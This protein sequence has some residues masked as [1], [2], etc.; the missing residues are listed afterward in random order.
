[1]ALAPAPQ[2]LVQQHIQI[3]NATVLVEIADTPALQQQGLSDRDSLEEGKGMWFVFPGETTQ[4]FWMK[5]MRFAID[6]IWVN[7][8]GVVVTIKH[9]AQPDSYPEIFYPS[10]TAQYVL[11]VPAGFTERHGIAEGTKV[12]L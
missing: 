2:Q 4:G 6:I 1:M 5:D 9:N 3:G 11:E 8:H 12:V 10:A 7:G